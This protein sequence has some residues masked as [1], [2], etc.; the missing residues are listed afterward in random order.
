[1]VPTCLTFKINGIICVALGKYDQHNILPEVWI[2]FVDWSVKSWFDPIRSSIWILNVR[3]YSWN[4]VIPMFTKWASIHQIQGYYVLAR[5]LLVEFEMCQAVII[6]FGSYLEA[7]WKHSV[8]SGAFGDDESIH[9]LQTLTAEKIA[10]KKVQVCWFQ[11]LKWQM[12]SE[13][14]FTTVFNFMPQEC[15]L[16]ISINSALYW[17]QAFES[18]VSAV[19]SLFLCL[20]S[21]PV[22]LAARCHLLHR[23]SC[24]ISVQYKTIPSIICSSYLISVRA[25]CMFCNV[26]CLL[27]YLSLSTKPDEHHQCLLVCR[28]LC[29]KMSQIVA[30][31]FCDTLKSL[32]KRLPAH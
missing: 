29:K 3:T 26:I 27:Q 30:C 11:W 13:R 2:L 14:I 23:A 28:S 8:E 15:S 21:L 4:H 16:A 5:A 6:S 17:W 25:L 24:S 19:F 32:S 20:R 9:T 7:E 10:A 22:L 18:I 1:M 31:F 12:L